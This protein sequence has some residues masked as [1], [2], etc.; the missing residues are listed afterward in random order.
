MA[1]KLYKL[2]VLC[3][4]IGETA[5]CDLVLANRK[6]SENNYHPN[7]ELADQMDLEAKELAKL[8]TKL[9]LQAVKIHENVE[10]EHDQKHGIVFMTEV[11]DPKDKHEMCQEGRPHCMK[12]TMEIKP[13]VNMTVSDDKEMP[14]P[15]NNTPDTRFMHVKDN[16]NKQKEQFRC[17]T[18]G[19]FFRDTNK[20]N[21]HL[22]T[23]QFDLFRCMKCKKVC[24]SQFSFEEHM[25][26]HYGTEI[27]CN[28]CKQ[29]FDLK[30][31]LINHMQKH[32][33]H[34]VHCETCGKSFQYRQNVVEHIQYTHRDKKT[35]PCLVCSKMFRMPT[36]MHSH[37]SRHHG[38]VDD[39]VYHLNSD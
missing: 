23:H 30:S 36:N 18:C 37:R 32:S 17:D 9:N 11:L 13:V 19:K 35:V 33:E 15:T 7:L 31:S 12:Y 1:R 28:I 38:L 5:A 10:A 27:R 6:T 8:S 14:C 3:K 16:S 34:K 4:Q 21:N 25:Q 24:R 26:T 20:L 2:K 39:I 22:S 29:Q